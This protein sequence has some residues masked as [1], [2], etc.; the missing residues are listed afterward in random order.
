MVLQLNA[1]IPSVNKV[2]FSEIATDAKQIQKFQ[3]PILQNLKK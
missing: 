2:V 3:I 1:K